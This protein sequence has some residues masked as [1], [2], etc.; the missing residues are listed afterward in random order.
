[1]LEIFVTEVVFVYT[2]AQHL[3]SIVALCM[4][5]QRLSIPLSATLDTWPRRYKTFFVLNLSEHKIYHAHCW[6]FNIYQHDK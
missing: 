5:D 6:H 2:N 1:M 3:D 4:M